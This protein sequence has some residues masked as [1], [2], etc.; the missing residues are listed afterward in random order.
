MAVEIEFKF[1]GAKDKAILN[2][3]EISK[4]LIKAIE[5]SKKLIDYTGDAFSFRIAEKEVITYMDM[6]NY[7]VKRLAKSYKDDTADDFLLTVGFT[8]NMYYITGLYEKIGEFNIQK[9]CN[10][11]SEDDVKKYVQLIHNYIVSCIYC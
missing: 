5:I 9:L 2:A 3:I 8:L 10:I 7:V 4:E 11:I 1:E 6:E